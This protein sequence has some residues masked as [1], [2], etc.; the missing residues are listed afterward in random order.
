MRDCKP[1]GEVE[2]VLSN[3]CWKTGMLGRNEVMPLLVILEFVRL[4]EVQAALCYVFTSWWRSPGRRM[5]GNKLTN[6]TCQLPHHT[7]FQ[8][9]HF[10]CSVQQPSVFGKKNITPNLQVSPLSIRK[11]SGLPKVTQW[12]NGTAI[13][14]YCPFTQNLPSLFSFITPIVLQ[15]KASMV[16]HPGFQ[17]KCLRM[18]KELEGQTGKVGERPLSLSSM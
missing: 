2:L 17:K 9:H 1:I 4:W 15:W 16:S 14:S 7:P 6:A 10:M 12:F 8:S 13:I 5:G 18:G 3:C 11:L